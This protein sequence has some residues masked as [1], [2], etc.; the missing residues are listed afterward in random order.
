MEKEIDYSR[1]KDE[2]SFKMAFVKEMKKNL[3]WKEVFCI[4][5]EETILGFPDV[6]TLTQ[7]N[8]AC[9]FEFKFSDSSGKIKFK[10]TQPAFYKKHKN[11]N[12]Q[13]VAYNKKKNKVEKFLVDALFGDTPYKIN[14]F[15][16]VKL[17]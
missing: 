12:I 10:P 3:Y 6:M 15:A 17:P 2:Q 1:C 5:T 8:I 11:M 13:V 16:E 14:N 4:E 9:F 7:S